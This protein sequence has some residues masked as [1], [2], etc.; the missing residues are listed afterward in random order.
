M[1]KERAGLARCAKKVDVIDGTH[2]ADWNLIDFKK[3][4]KIKR[5]TGRPHHVCVGVGL[6]VC[7]CVCVCVFVWNIGLHMLLR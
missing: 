6:C 2:D 5:Q 1:R 4:R 7:V 3:K